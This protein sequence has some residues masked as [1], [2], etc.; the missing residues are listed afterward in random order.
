M[1]R[2]VS[3]WAMLAILLSTSLTISVFAV[4]A[5]PVTPFMYETKNVASLYDSQTSAQPVAY[6]QLQTVTVVK[7]DKK[8]YLIRTW[9][10]EKWIIYK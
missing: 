4:V 9:I 1:K 8:W 3:L 7:V 2:R 6:I 10:G 5:I